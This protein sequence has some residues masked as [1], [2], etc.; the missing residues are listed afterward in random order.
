MKLNLD[1]EVAKSALL[2]PDPLVDALALH[3]SAGGIPY[4]RLVEEN[5]RRGQF[6]L[7]FEPVDT[8]GVDDGRYWEITADYAKA[9]LTGDPLTAY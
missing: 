1:A 4:T 6:D 7:Q 3:V 8:G 9:G 2:D 5:A